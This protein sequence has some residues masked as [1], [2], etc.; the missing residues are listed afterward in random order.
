MNT[1]RRPLTKPTDRQ[2]GWLLRIGSSH[3]FSVKP[4][5]PFKKAVMH[6]PVHSPH[7]HQINSASL[8]CGGGRLDVVG[9]AAAREGRPPVT[10]EACC[11][12]EGH[13][14]ALGVVEA[15]VAVG[16]VP[17]VEVGV[18]DLLG[19]TG[20]LGDVLTGHLEMHTAEMRAVRLVCLEC[21]EELLEHRV[22]AARFVAA[23][24][25]LSVAVHRVALEDDIQTSLFG[26]LDERRQVCLDVLGPQPRDEHQ[27]ARL[28]LRVEPLAQVDNL[29]GRG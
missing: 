7:T 25:L 22:E 10:L 27:L 11:E 2:A 15:G 13:L 24:G 16:R 17:Y 8:V 9:T 18:V 14:E 23:A 1:Q 29:A 12:F 6:T 4:I 26:S 20:A 5:G 28:V 19:P 21:L 3:S